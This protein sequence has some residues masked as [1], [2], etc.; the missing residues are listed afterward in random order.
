M[1]AIAEAAVTAI[2]S[3]TGADSVCTAPRITS[4]IR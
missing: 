4:P 1:T 3:A 2:V